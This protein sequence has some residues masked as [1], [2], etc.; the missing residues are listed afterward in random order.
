MVSGRASVGCRLP[1]DLKE[2]LIK[3]RASSGGKIQY[4][5]GK[6][7]ESNYIPEIMVESKRCLF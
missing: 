6:G 2:S 7:L 5:L 1:L 3:I 4:G